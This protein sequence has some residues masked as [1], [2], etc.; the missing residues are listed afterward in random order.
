M[1]TI[2]ALTPQADGTKT[3]VVSV[4]HEEEAIDVPFIIQHSKHGVQIYT[5]I[6]FEIATC[7]INPTEAEAMIE[8][9]NMLEWDI[10]AV[11]GA[12]RS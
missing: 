5:P 10:A 9:C 3:G 8:F 6:D 12:V 7:T 11:R 2:T 4:Y 1:L